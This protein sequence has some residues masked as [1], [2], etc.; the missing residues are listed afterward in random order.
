MITEGTMF[1]KLIL[2]ITMFSLIGT[3]VNNSSEAFFFFKKKK[4]EKKIEAEATKEEKK[5]LVTEIFAKWCPACRNIQPTLDLLVKESIDIE[6]IQLDVSTQEK[7]VESEKKATILKI[8]DFYRANKSKTSTVAIFV[9]TT[10]ELV[11]IFQNNN[12]IDQYKTAIQDAKTRE[13][14]LENPPS[15]K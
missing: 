12:D 13:K 6:L 5:V 11:A 8:E 14:S 3:T 2:L 7:A 4:P 9:P 15:D 10:S 1:K